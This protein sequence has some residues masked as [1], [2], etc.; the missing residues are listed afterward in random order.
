MKIPTFSQILFVDVF[1]SIAAPKITTHTKKIIIDIP[2]IPSKFGYAK[3][4]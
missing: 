2:R 3:A 1:F 4:E